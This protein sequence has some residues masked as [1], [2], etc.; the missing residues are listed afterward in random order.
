MTYWLPFML[1]PVLMISVSV[2]SSFHGC[3][4]S[5]YSMIA[6]NGLGDRLYT[7]EVFI[8]VRQ[9]GCWVIVLCNI[10]TYNYIV[11]Y[12]KRWRQVSRLMVLTV[13]G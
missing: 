4:H 9:Q 1:S 12:H 3:K 6:R 13:D 2:L 5:S 11:V 7:V 10:M 8:I